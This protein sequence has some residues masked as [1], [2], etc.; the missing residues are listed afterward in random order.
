VYCKHAI[1]V[2]I[3]TAVKSQKSPACAIFFGQQ[4]LLAIAVMTQLCFKHVQ[5]R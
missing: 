2:N 5:L 3:P 4:P 1:L